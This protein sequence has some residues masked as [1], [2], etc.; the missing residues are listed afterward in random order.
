MV[1]RTS[2]CFRSTM[3]MFRQGTTAAYTS[4][5]LLSTEGLVLCY[6][7]GFLLFSGGDKNWELKVSEDTRKKS[8]LETANRGL[9]EVESE[10]HKRHQEEKEKR[11]YNEKEE[12][13]SHASNL[14][15][16]VG[17]DD[18]VQKVLQ[19][20][21]LQQDRLGRR[22][23]TFRQ[24]PRL[25]VDRWRREHRERAERRLLRNERRRLTSC[26]AEC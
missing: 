11:K 15:K 20:D 14:I 26:L 1:S 13:I 25:A 24:E 3:L 23:L 16:K 6:L 7:V 8:E 22:V 9:R 2:T 5:R 4:G 18:R 10:K 12:T 19:R 21:H 17:P